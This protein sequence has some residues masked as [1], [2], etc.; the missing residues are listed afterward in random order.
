M[1]AFPAWG[2]TEPGNGVMSH[3][4]DDNAPFLKAC[5]GEPADFTPIWLMRQAGRYMEEYREVRER[6]PFMELCKNSDLAAEVTVT[7]VERI[8]ADAAI[9]F[10][11]ILLILTPMGMSLSYGKGEGPV[12]SNPVRTSADVDRLKEAPPEALSFVYDAIRKTRAS[13]NPGTPLI[14]FCGAPFT[15]A[16]YVIEGGGSRNYIETKSLMY[17]DSGAWQALM[18]V[19]TRSLVK[20]V[21]CQIGAGAQAIQI[22]DSWVGCLSPADYREFVFPHIRLLLDNISGEVPIIHFG[23]GTATLLEDQKKAGGDVIGL[24][25]RVNLGETWDRLGGVAIQGNMDPCVL[26]ADRATIRK[27]AEDILRQAKGRPGHIFN[28]GHGVL[29]PTPVDNVKFLVDL[30]HEWKAQ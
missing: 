18:S 21:K 11:D 23:T 8:G 5:R 24:D 1:V 9:I 26:L 22:F 7:A 30:V 29:P 4:S 16:S 10:S 14:G 19:I 17:G 6:T 27:C 3:M 15:L 20:Y 28:L 25:W 13:L 12:L 2:F